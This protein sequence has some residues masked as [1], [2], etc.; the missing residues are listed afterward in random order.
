M[1]K[2][3]LKRTETNL[4]ELKLKKKSYLRCIKKFKYSIRTGARCQQMSTSLWYP[5]NLPT[6]RLPALI[7][8]SIG[9]LFVC[10][11]LSHHEW[12]VSNVNSLAQNFMKYCLNI[13]HYQFTR[14]SRGPKLFHA[15][16]IVA[17]TWC[18][19]VYLSEY[20][21]IFFLLPLLN[22]LVLIECWRCDLS[23][24]LEKM[25]LSLLTKFSIKSQPLMA[26][27]NLLGY[28]N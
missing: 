17:T 2:E 4:K 13:T 27:T 10:N 18:L 26:C 5:P 25:Y 23:G 1:L 20:F 9:N 6:L 22:V 11:I 28:Y 16:A 8:R 21:K 12:I 14:G 3:E 24:I 15:S 7:F 19:V